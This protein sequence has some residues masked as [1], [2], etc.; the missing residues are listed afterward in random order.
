MNLISS[1]V[2]SYRL[3]PLS[4]IK[5]NKGWYRII[6]S[7]QAVVGTFLGEKMHDYI[8]KGNHILLKLVERSKGIDRM[9]GW[10]YYIYSL[11]PFQLVGDCELHPNRYN[12]EHEYVG[13]I[14]Y[15]IKPEYQGLGYAKEAM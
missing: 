13:N 8:I 4:K 7:L 10:Y 3:K 14:G 2:N 15:E 6:C 1:V 9:A 11:T 12:L 5:L